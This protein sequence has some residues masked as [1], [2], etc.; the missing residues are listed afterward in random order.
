MIAILKGSKE[1]LSRGEIAKLLDDCPTKVSFQLSRLIK[2]NEIGSVE[3]EREAA[4]LKFN[5]NRRM[6]LY[7]FINSE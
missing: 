3:I 4:K 6:K 1:P 2:Y 7:F 5:C